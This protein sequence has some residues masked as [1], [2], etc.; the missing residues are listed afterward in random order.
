MSSRL[1]IEYYK[2]A[3]TFSTFEESVAVLH[4]N[5]QNML[6][7]PL[8]KAVRERTSH[9]CQMPVTGILLQIGQSTFLYGLCGQCAMFDV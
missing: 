4:N 7:I 5:A 3:S 2:L 9:D 6:G 1:S 8:A